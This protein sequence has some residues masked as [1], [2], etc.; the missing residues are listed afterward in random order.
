M[1]LCV[2]DVNELCKQL[3]KQQLV[4]AWQIDECRSQISRQGFTP[5]VLLEWLQSRGW[6]TSYQVLHLKKGDFSS[7]VLGHYKVLY[8]VSAGS[9]AR[10]YRAAD[11]RNGQMVALK[12]LRQRWSNDPTAVQQFR[13]EAEL[14]KTL[15]HPNIVPIFDVGRNGDQHFFSMEFVEGGNLRELLNIRKKLA[16]AEATKCVLEMTEGL[17]YAVS[18]GF[19]HRD[20]KPTNVLM[21]STGVAKLVDF[22]LAGGSLFKA[23][24]DEE[25]EQ[26]A[27]DYAVLEDGTGAPR[28]DPRSDLY[29]LGAIYYE[30]LS[31]VSPLTRTRDRY[32]RSQF[33]RFRDVTPLRELEPMFPRMVLQIVDKLMH[34]NPQLRYQS[35]ADVLRDLRS[36][37]ADV[38]DGSSI[39]SPSPASSPRPMQA[40]VVTVMCVETRPRQQDMLRDYF[41]K[42]GYRVLVLSEISRG[43]QRLQ[44][45]P[46]DAVV[47]M[48]EGIGERAMSAFQ[49]I[50]NLP[51]G[52]PVA[53]VIVVAETQ[54]AWLDRLEQTSNSR[55]LQQPMTLRDLRK[56][57]AGLLKE[58]A[59]GSGSSAGTAPTASSAASG[60][61][62]GRAPGKDK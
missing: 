22:G 31:G 24:T 7:L 6:L 54:K 53:R 44:Q 5:D 47:L 27:L 36:T 25:A 12:V 32:E 18:K 21:S 14:G 38:R 46:P 49:E 19:M 48:A 11:L 60:S 42:H 26:R 51:A 40:P 17:A 4:T 43:L 45:N 58:H 29:F 62:V 20:L 50:Q 13:K 15:Q 56:S 10:V 37:Y 3:Q 33:S 57:L 34:L 9:F 55:I 23:E 52:A 59:V 28:N 16:S 8:R 61:S 39:I 2:M 1:L 41:S 30:L 35:A